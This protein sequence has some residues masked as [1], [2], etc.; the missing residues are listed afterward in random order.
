MKTL[1]P[2]ALIL[3]SQLL[4]A[5]NYKWKEYNF[6]EHEFT[7][8]FPH[9]PSK[10]KSASEVESGYIQFFNF[11]CAA[12]DLK[13]IDSNTLYMASAVNYPV[14]ILRSEDSVVANA[15]LDEMILAAVEK[16][17]GKLL[18]K[19][20]INFNSIPGK[21]VKILFTNKI[22]GGKNV[23]R[24]RYYFLGDKVFVVQTITLP[25]NDNNTFIN[26]FMDSFIIHREPNSNIKKT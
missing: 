9:P 26:K 1:L 19:K 6:S 20:D 24:I 16:V 7:I 22:L 17:N 14:K 21:Q 3:V 13:G 10:E 11:S 8:T 5:Q 18:Y 25:Q 15:V 2:F 23:S 4:V 12:N